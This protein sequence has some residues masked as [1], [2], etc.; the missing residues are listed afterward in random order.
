MAVFMTL[1]LPLVL[2]VALSKADKDGY[3][4]WLPDMM[5]APYPLT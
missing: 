2:I 5:Q 3:F 4:K 1:A